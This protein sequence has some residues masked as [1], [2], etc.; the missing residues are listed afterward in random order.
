MDKASNG[1]VTVDGSRLMQGETL[2]AVVLD[3][4]QADLIATA[5]NIGLMAMQAASKGR[6]SKPQ[7]PT[8]SKGK[9][10]KGLTKNGTPRKRAPR[11]CG[12]CGEE[13]HDKRNCGNI[14]LG[15]Q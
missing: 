11:T 12:S 5:L 10:V 2:I 6:A 15:G 13:G 7:A 8:K 3:D 9:P 14:H 4:E 1:M